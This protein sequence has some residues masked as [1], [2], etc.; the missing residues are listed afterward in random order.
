MAEQV[1]AAVRIGPSTT[2]MREFPK[3]RGNSLVAAPH[4][5]SACSMTT[6]KVT[7]LPHARSS[8]SWSAVAY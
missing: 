6:S 3:Y 8:A 4:A 5:A 7:A 2:E 1:L